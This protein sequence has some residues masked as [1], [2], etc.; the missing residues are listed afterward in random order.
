[1]SKD[2][3]K[4][5]DRREKGKSVLVHTAEDSHINL[6]SVYKLNLLVWLY[7]YVL[8]VY[9]PVGGKRWRWRA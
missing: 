7:M 4:W 6:G 3:E 2:E 8:A 9:V 1:M 5:K